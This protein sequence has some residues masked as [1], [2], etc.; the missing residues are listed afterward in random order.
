MDVRD[1]VKKYVFKTCSDR[2]IDEK[3]NADDELGFD[4]LDMISLCMELEKEFNINIGDDE[5]E[6][7][8]SQLPKLSVEKFIDYLSVFIEG[9][10]K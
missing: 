1:T 3:G 9:K 10:I 4:S 8:I 5:L 2:A 7:I 6:L